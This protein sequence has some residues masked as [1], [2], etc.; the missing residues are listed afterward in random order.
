M[1]NTNSIALDR[2]AFRGAPHGVSHVWPDEVLH[3][4]QWDRHHWSFDEML[5]THGRSPAKPSFTRDSALD[6]LNKLLTK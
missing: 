4:S 1:P 3:P 6:L 2:H 5:K